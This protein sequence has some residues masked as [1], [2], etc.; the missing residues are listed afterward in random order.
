VGGERVGGVRNR[1][2]SKG[3]TLVETAHLT[4]LTRV[5][6]THFLKGKRG[7]CKG[8]GGGKELLCLEVGCMNFGLP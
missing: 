3:N 5:G 7:L 4:A 2:R 1:P 6:E 8:G